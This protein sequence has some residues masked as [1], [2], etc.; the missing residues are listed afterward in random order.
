M[1]VSRASRTP[2]S[3]ARFINFSFFDKCNAP[4]NNKILAYYI[5]RTA[6]LQVKE[7]MVVI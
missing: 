5:I 3:F 7:K 1:S 2:S 6:P 4:P